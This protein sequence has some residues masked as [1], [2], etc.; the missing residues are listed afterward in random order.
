MDD[1]YADRS[2]WPREETEG[3]YRWIKGAEG[4]W[5]ESP[6]TIKGGCRRKFK[7]SIEA[8]R[9]AF[10]DDAAKEMVDYLDSRECQNPST[11]QSAVQKSE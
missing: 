4:K 11:L 9:L 2:P 10:G 8:W 6:V 3:E 1:L 5:F 7:A